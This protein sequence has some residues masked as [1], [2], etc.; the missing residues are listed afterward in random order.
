[1]ELRKYVRDNL[2]SVELE[3]ACCYL[4]LDMDHPLQASGASIV[5]YSAVTLLIVVA[6]LILKGGYNITAFLRTS[7]KS[8]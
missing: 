1:V 3:V 6:Y 8:T 2:A 4:H 7:L 5:F